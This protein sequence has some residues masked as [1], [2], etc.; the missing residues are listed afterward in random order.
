MFGRVARRARAFSFLEAVAAAA[1]LGIVAASLLS[2]AS[3]GTAT[4]LRRERR[5]AAMD[6]ANQ[7]MIA[8]LDDPVNTT[9]ERTRELFTYG[10]DSEAYR[11]RVVVQAAKIDESRNAR[12]ARPDDRQ[13]PVT[14]DKL[15]EVTIEVWFDDGVSLRGPGDG[16]SARL[17]RIVNPFAFRNPDSMANTVNDPELRQRLI[18]RMIGPGSGP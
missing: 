11:W 18:E 4:Q 7:L 3:F 2:A 12:A 16:P 8:W 5:A 15:E 10:R 17:T 1:L 6:I 9:P 13:T 14:F